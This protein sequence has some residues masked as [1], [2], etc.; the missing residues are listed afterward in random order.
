MAAKLEKIFNIIEEKLGTNGRVKLA[1]LTKV[2]KTQ[3]AEMADSPETVAV[4][5]RIASELLGKNI[6][7]IQ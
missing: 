3:A 1:Q 6:D 2:T 5:K 4:F 7:E